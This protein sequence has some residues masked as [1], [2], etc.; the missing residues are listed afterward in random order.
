MRETLAQMRC[1]FI[2]AGAMLAAVMIGAV[3]LHWLL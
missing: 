2:A 1:E 3:L